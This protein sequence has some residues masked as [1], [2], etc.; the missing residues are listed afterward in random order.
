MTTTEEKS[1][2][3]M[4][5]QDQKQLARN[6]RP[7]GESDKKTSVEGESV[8]WLELKST[9]TAG[10]GWGDHSK[11]FAKMDKISSLSVLKPPSQHLFPR[12]G[13]C[14]YPLNLP[15]LWEKHREGLLLV[16]IYGI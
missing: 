7:L 6:A 16:L 10:D 8:P 14:S 12:R 9:D 4:E 3:A 15:C 13:V 1:I 11:S 5:Q 2:L